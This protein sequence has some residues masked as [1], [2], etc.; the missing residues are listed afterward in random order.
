MRLWGTVRGNRAIARLEAAAALTAL[1]AWTFSIAL[2]LYAYYEDGPGGVALAV[3]VRMLPAA[4][5]APLAER[6]AEGRRRRNVLAGAALVRLALLEAI[7]VVVANEMAFGLLLALAAGVEL[8]GAVQRPARAALL[9]EVAATPGELAAA[10]AWRFAEGIGFLAGGT[11]AAILVAHN[12][13]DTAFAA[14]GAPFAFVALLAWRVPA[15]A[16]SPRHRSLAGGLRAGVDAIARHSWMRVRLGLFAVSSL[17]QSMLE[18]LLVVAALDL[19]GVGSSGVGWLRAALAAGGLAG[20]AGALAALRRGRLGPGLIAGLVLAGAPLALVAAWPEA[21]PVAVLLLALGAGYALLETALLL[22]TQRLVPPEAIARAAGIEEIV[23]PLARAAGTGIAAWLVVALGETEALVVG[24]LVLPLVALLAIPAL[25]RAERQVEVPDA[26]FRVLRS[27]PAFAQ[28]PRATLE[29]LALCAGEE[30][31]EADGA[32]HGNG[33][34]AI[35]SGTV[36]VDGARLGPGDCFGEAALLRDAAPAVPATA[37][38]EVTT[39]TIARA[40]FIVRV[41]AV[42]LGATED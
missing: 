18:L 22:L 34:R 40:A 16:R 29:N 9:V 23:Y 35:A 12:G 36:E 4:V 38:T 15:D 27:L 13:L 10:S 7:A 11:L 2:A 17:V 31:F 1:G 24:G 21:A 42:H 5:F 33:F 32:I 19:V 14:A 41:T 3:A 6:V 30:R 28:L 39:V 25:R 26:A 8:A 37:V 20:G